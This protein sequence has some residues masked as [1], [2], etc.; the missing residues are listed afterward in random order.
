MRILKI[1][2]FLT[3]LYSATT[4][5]QV[6]LDASR[7][8]LYIEASG[9]NGSDGRDG[10]NSYYSRGSSGEDGSRGSDGGDVTLSMNYTNGSKT[11]IEVQIQIPN[12]GVNYK[13]EFSLQQLK[14]IMISARGGNGGDGGDGG[15]GG[16]GSDGRDGSD[17]C[18]PSSG[19]NGSDGDNGG[20]GGDGG[21]GG[22]GGQIKIYIPEFQSELL[23][24]IKGMDNSPGRGGD[25]GNGGRG[26]DGGDGGDGGRNTCEQGGTD[27]WDGS[28]GSD[29]RNGSS[30]SSGSTG[31]SGTHAFILSGNSYTEKY[32]LEIKNLEY[33][34]E[35]LDGLIEY[36]EKITIRRLTLTNTSSM[37]SPKD[38]QLNG[39]D[40]VAGEFSWINSDEIGPIKSLA[41][42][43]SIV[44]QIPSGAMELQ[45]MDMKKFEDTQT[46]IPL[47]F[48]KAALIG[49]F[50]Q[51]PTATIKRL[52]T[53][54]ITRSQEKLFWGQSRDIELTIINQSALP[55]GKGTSR[56]VW[57][58]ATLKSKLVTIKDIKLAYGQSV[59]NFN[60]NGEGIVELETLNKGPNSVKLK[61]TI[62]NRSEMFAD[63]N[64]E[65]SLVRSAVRPTNHEFRDV[66]DVKSTKVSFAKDLIAE[67]HTFILPLKEKTYCT[68]GPKN[69]KR[70]L[71]QIS[72]T[73][74]ANTSTVEFGLTLSQLVFFKKQLPKVYNG[75]HELAVYLEDLK[76]KTLTGPKLVS[77]LNDYV[78]P[79]TITTM[80]STKPEW[81][82]NNCFQKTK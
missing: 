24:L 60:E 31:L 16:D 9:H 48:S 80:S 10:S 70:R 69:S 53:L 67:A 40:G 38:I 51:L 3:L 36:G 1:A 66:V 56:N 72:I 2:P 23:M 27:G 45:T 63:A 55:M 8:T 62:G 68:F 32:R 75:R 18:L 15:N 13:N 35:N 34:D 22:R 47:G 81:V 39:L 5:A 25:A 33:E 14:N 42:N 82:I 76:A 59:F 54:A 41:K 44:V 46:R 30:G 21:S 7:G 78:K 4:M 29:G 74:Q 52:G 19:S 57:L 12:K 64:F 79:G 37:P 26:G 43:E 77:F 20:A 58:K 61:F 50:D 65:F 28:D 73:K 49:I 17:G 71:K 6:S 11:A